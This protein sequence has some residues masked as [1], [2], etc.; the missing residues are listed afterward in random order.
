MRKPQ[1]RG[2]PFSRAYLFLA[3]KQGRGE[4]P[5]KKWANSWTQ[6]ISISG[7]RD[8]QAKAC[9]NRNPQRL[10]EREI[11]SLSHSIPL[12][13]IPH[14]TLPSPLIMIYTLSSECTWG[15]SEENPRS[16]MH[17]K[18]R[19][20]AA[21]CDSHYVSQLAAFFIEVRAEIS[22]VGSRV[23]LILFFS[24]YIF[25]VGVCGFFLAC[26]LKKHTYTHTLKKEG[27]KEYK[28]VLMTCFVN[29]IS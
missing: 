23:K 16:R 8:S 10:N 29:L 26:G 9:R 21:A 5:L 28:F 22:I 27:E 1:K 15:Y 3:E 12:S 20:L 13:F 6:S 2:S 14:F 18:T 19:W 4:D 7:V 11:K 17:S 25:K 24:L